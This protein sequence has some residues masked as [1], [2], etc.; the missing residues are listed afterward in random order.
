LDLSYSCLVHWII[1]YV[2]HIIITYIHNPRTPSYIKRF[3][4]AKKDRPKFALSFDVFIHD[5]DIKSK[6]P[7]AVTC[8]AI[9]LL[10]RRDGKTPKQVFQL[11]IAIGYEV[12]SSVPCYF[13]RRTL[14]ISNFFLKRLPLHKYKRTSTYIFS[15]SHI[16]KT[17]Y[18]I[19]NISAKQSTQLHKTDTQNIFK[20]K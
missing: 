1:S 9:I 3:S 12:W 18:D 5:E 2:I 4:L 19:K 7:S 17:G 11:P 15:T 16:K 14:G 8:R 6:W 20:N 13:K 10:R